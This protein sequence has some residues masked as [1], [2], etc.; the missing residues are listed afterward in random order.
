MADSTHGKK[1]KKS[2]GG[3]AGSSSKTVELAKKLAAAVIREH[4][5]PKEITDELASSGVSQEVLERIGGQSQA[6]HV[7]HQSKGRPRKR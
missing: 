6:D 1:G 4:G 3:K 5:L 2:T 7:P